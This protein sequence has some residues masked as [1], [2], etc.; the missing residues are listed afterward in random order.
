[1]NFFHYALIFSHLK[2]Q[3]MIVFIFLEALFVIIFLV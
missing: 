1:M 2:K 3:N